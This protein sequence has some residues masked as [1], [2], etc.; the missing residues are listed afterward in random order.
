MNPLHSD[1]RVVRRDFP[2]QYDF[3]LSIGS[4]RVRIYLDAGFFRPDHEWTGVNHN[5]EGC[6]LLLFCD[7]RPNTRCDIRCSKGIGS[8]RRRLFQ[9]SSKF[10]HANT[11]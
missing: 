2:E 5:T 4:L 7:K 9:Q 3:A 1:E 6:C 8:S 10:V 11:H